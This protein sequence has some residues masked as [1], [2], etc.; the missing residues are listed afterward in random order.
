MSMQDVATIPLHLVSLPWRITRRIGTSLVRLAQLTHHQTVSRH[1]Y[2]NRLAA[3]P[4][5]GLSFLR[6]HQVLFALKHAARN[7][8]EDE[9]AHLWT[10][11]L[12]AA[13]MAHDAIL[14]SLDEVDDS[15]S[16]WRGR[17]HRDGARWFMVMQRGPQA[18]MGATKKGLIYVYR[19]MRR[20]WR[21]LTRSLDHPSDH[22]FPHPMSPKSTSNPHPNSTSTSTSTSFYPHPTDFAVATTHD[23]KVWFSSHDAVERRVV[24]FRTLRARLAMALARIHAAAAPLALH[25]E[26]SHLGPPPP[27]GRD[28]RGQTRVQARTPASGNEN[29]VHDFRRHIGVESAAAPRSG[30]RPAGSLSSSSAPTSTSHRESDRHVGTGS[31]TASARVWLGA[32]TS[33]RAMPNR[34]SRSHGNT[35]GTSRAAGDGVD[36][37]TRRS[38]RDKFTFPNPTMDGE[39]S[40]TAPDA[41]PTSPRVGLPDSV[42]EDVAEDLDAGSRG[43]SGDSRAALLALGERVAYQTSLD[44]ADEMEMLREAL[45]VILGPNDRSGSGYVATPTTAIS[46]GGLLLPS[47][48]T[49]RH[50]TLPEHPGGDREGPGTVGDTPAHAHT[51]LSR[52]GFPGLGFLRRRWRPWRRDGFRRSSFER[53][54]PVSGNPG[55]ESVPLTTGRTTPPTSPLRVDV[56]NPVRDPPSPSSPKSPTSPATPAS[57]TSSLDRAGGRP[58]PE[59][60]SISGTTHPSRDATRRAVARAWVCCPAGPATWS[61]WDREF[62]DGTGSTWLPDQYLDRRDPQQHTDSSQIASVDGDRNTTTFIAMETRTTTDGI[63]YHP[64]PLSSP[65]T[66]SSAGAALRALQ[67][68]V[69]R[70]RRGG[71]PLCVLPLWSRVP[72]SLQRHWIWIVAGT[73]LT[74]PSVAWLYRHHRSGQLRTWV[75]DGVTKVQ[76]GFQNHVADPIGTLMRDLTAQF[77]DRANSVEKEDVVLSRASL[78]RMLLDFERDFGRTGRAGEAGKTSSGPKSGVNTGSDAQRAIHP[79]PSSMSLSTTTVD[80]ERDVVVS[81]R[82]EDYDRNMRLLMRRYE[83]DLKNPVLG[84]AKGALVRSMLIQV[85]KLKVDTESAMVELDAVIR[86]QELTLSLMAALPAILL[87]SAGLAAA[88]RTLAPRAPDERTKAVS[89]R[90]AAT[91]LERQLAQETLDDERYSYAGIDP[92]VQ[93][94]DAA[95]AALGLRMLLAARLHRELARVFGQRAD[96]GGAAE[97]SDRDNFKILA[98]ARA[99]TAAEWAVLREEL[100]QLETPMPASIHLATLQRMQRTY[101]IFKV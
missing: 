58:G 26:M 29:D 22:A 60:I 77:R 37:S 15:L 53:P 96:D 62:G 38:G 75:E 45:E 68:V 47:A 98:G 33:P 36:P 56:P 70:A 61:D 81:L 35:F 18:F 14:A 95:E 12:C 59:R 46:R 76:T 99:T 55:Q 101:R 32:W 78:R 30:F 89:I 21:R 8:D 92:R 71:Y 16:F 66:P 3:V 44:V 82:D 40:N 90:L 65:P 19:W 7:H 51:S 2:A 63:Y 73:A 10:T 11:A 97:E 34:A 23:S 49:R 43:R 24:L 9:I 48:P 86:S 57:R 83:E 31:H 94:M 41:T 6:A 52:M 67:R 80:P 79:E 93:R 1:R 20:R 64:A 28:S 5:A 74:V 72:T 17:M 42:D 13:Q 39:P 84:F 91:A 54:R 4:V 27:S 100:G 50:R 88:H 85:Q 25:D 69:S 87:A